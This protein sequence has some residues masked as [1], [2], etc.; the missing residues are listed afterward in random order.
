MSSDN[1]DRI[2]RQMDFIVN[3]QAQF[4]VDIQKLQETQ[5]R[6]E[7]RMTRIEDVVLRLANVT[8]H[9]I[10]ELAEAQ[11]RTQAQVDALA[12]QSRETDRRLRDTNER[13]DAVIGMAERFFSGR[14]P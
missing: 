7:E 3:N 14:Q 8:E 2:Q 11:T 5:Q 13:L 6:A 1:Q 12:E 4:S 9:R 10:A